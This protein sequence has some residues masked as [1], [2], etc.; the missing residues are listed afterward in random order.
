MFG[1]NN[2][3]DCSNMCH[4]SSGAALGEAIG[5][6]KGTV[7][8]KDIEEADCVLVV[9]QNP[10]TNHPRMLSAL[11]ETVR[12]GGEIVAVNPMKEAGLI[13]FAHPQ[14]ITGMM[15]A[16][17]PLA[18]DYLRVKIN[19]D[20]ALFQGLMKSIFDLEEARPGEV[21]DQAF[22][23]EHTVGFDAFAGEIRSVEWDEIVSRSGISEE[24]IREV[25]LK[26]IRKDKKLI[27]CWAMGLTQHRNAVSTIR[28]VANLHLMLGA[29]G[30]PGAGLCP[31]RGHSNVQGD[32]TM[33]IFEKMPKAF[34]DSIDKVFK[35]QSPREVGYDVVNSIFAMHEKKASVFFAMGGNFLQATP[36]T[37]FTAEALRNCSLT[38]QVSTKLNRS[39]VVTGKTG[40]SW[41]LMNRESHSSPQ[42]RIQWAS[43]IRVKELLNLP[44][45]IF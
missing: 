4:E 15:G 11:Q 28:D 43:F 26:L 10:G 8:L 12:N 25:A 18:S 38:V 31:V 24:E 16:S 17:T 44:R 22:I 14:E 39:H 2:L 37:E 40:V 5:V 23:E 6:G 20:Q 3:P 9:G 41:I 21:L 45:T 42:W 30:R 34:H 7:S 32:R 1:T 35:F 33:G 29:I 36:D 19:G 27:T 13:G